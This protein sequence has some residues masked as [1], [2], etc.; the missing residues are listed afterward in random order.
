M[1]P[2]PIYVI[3]EE[4]LTQLEQRLAVSSG[5]TMERTSAKYLQ[6]DGLTMYQDWVVTFE[7]GVRVII[8]GH[9]SGQPPR[10]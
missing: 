2:F 6:S 9:A 1:S 7:T 4:I 5:A 3:N 8:M 10:K